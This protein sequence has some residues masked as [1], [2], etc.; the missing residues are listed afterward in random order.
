MTPK[1][2]S[3]RSPGSRPTSSTIR[4]YSASVR[5]TRAARSTPGSFMLP[6]FEFLDHG[7]QNEQAVGPAQQLLRRPLGMW[8]HAGHITLPVDDARNVRDRTVWIVLLVHRAVRGAVAKDHLSLL[9]HNSQRRCVHGI[10][11]IAMSNGQPEHLP[12]L[13]AACEHSVRILDAHRYGVAEKGQVTVAQ[14]GARQQTC[15]CEQLEAVADAQD[16]ASP[17]GKPDHHLHERCEPRDGSR[18]QVIAVRETARQDHAVEAR[19][20]RLAM[21]EILDIPAKNIVKSTVRIYVAVGTREDGNRKPHAPSSKMVQEYASTT[22]LA[23]SCSLMRVS[24]ASAAVRSPSGSS[25][26]MTLP[27]RTARTPVNPSVWS[28]CSTAVPWGSAI[29][30]LGPIRTRAFITPSQSA[31]AEG[32]PDSPPRPHPDRDGSGPCPASFLLRCPRNGRYPARS[33]RQGGLLRL[34]VQTPP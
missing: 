22:V 24:A 16:H 25:K 2:S 31:G 7:L 13:A 8:H 15:F 26:S 33:R 32:L 3:S 18:P 12:S 1:R 30:F 11:T 20:V 27:T 9:L 17:A 6:P 14:Q 23:R 4:A 5:P 19:Q 34:R 21:P 10:V 28:A 29:P